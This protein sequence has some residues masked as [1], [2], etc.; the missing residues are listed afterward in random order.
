[1]KKKKGFVFVETLVV[2][3]ILT[4][5]LLASY[6]T[7]SALIIKEKGRISY[8]DSVYLYRTYYLEKFFKNFYLGA[9]KTEVNHINEIGN[10]Q[11][12]KGYSVVGCSETILPQEPNQTV[13]RNKG[14]CDLIIYNLHVDKLFLMYKD[15]GYLQKCNNWE[16]DCAIF[17]VLDDG[18]A[19]YVKTIG[20]SSETA[21]QASLSGYRM[22]AGYKE[23]KD[24]SNCGEDSDECQTFYSTVS[25]GDIDGK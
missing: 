17:A 7:Y 19:E 20:G 1:M 12:R 14:V 18:M 3:A 5:S 10:T 11:S 2:T 9:A 4:V 16:G 6:S 8:N 24:G 25:I 23:K 13:N 22:V 21:E 15:L